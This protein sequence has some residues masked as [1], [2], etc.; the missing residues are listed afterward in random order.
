MTRAFWITAYAGILYFAFVRGVGNE[1]EHALLVMGMF[2]TAALLV[3]ALG[4]GD[5]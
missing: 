5:D 1:F 4:S 2:S 3:I